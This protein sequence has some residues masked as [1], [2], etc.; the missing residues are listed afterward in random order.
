MEKLDTAYSLKPYPHI[1]VAVGTVLHVEIVDLKLR[2]KSVLI[3][4]ENGRYLIAKL[5]NNDLSGSVRL[6][7]AIR[8]QIIIKYV[9]NGFVYGFKTKVLNIISIPARL[10][11]VAY[12]EEIEELSIRCDPRYECVLPVEIKIGDDVIEMVIVDISKTGCGCVI[13]TDAVENKK[14]MFESLNMDTKIDLKAQ[15]PGTEPKLGLAGKIMHIYKDDHTITLGVLFE[16]M[17]P[18]VKTEFDKFI[19]WISKL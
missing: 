19:L 15:L 4:I 14:Q 7:R 11:F 18:G 9:Y 10:L 1:P 16:E 6:Q 17:E 3:G 12:P 5:P 13:K 2:H 8:S